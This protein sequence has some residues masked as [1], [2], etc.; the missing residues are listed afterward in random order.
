MHEVVSRE[1]CFRGLT[2]NIIY[3]SMSTTILEGCPHN[4]NLGLFPIDIHRRV[5]HIMS[6]VGVCPIHIHR[7]VVHKIDYQS[8]CTIYI[9]GL[10][11]GKYKYLCLE[12]VFIHGKM[13][14]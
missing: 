14:V 10:S 1:K 5:V 7:R 8:V 12:T 3:R 11:T 13:H 9:G 2:N 4:I 6:I